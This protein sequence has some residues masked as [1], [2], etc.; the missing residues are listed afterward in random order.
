MGRGPA[1]PATVEQPARHR[2]P[3]LPRRRR[4]GPHRRHRRFRRRHPDLPAHS[5]R[6]PGGRVRPGEHDLGSHAG[7]VRLREPGPPAHRSEQHRDRR[8]RGAPPA[9]DGLGHGRL[10]R[11]HP[12]PRVPRRAP[13]LRALRGRRPRPHPPG[14]RRAQL[15]PGQPGGGLRLLPPLPPRRLGGAGPGGTPGSDR[16]G[17]LARLPAEP[18]LRPARASTTRPS[19]GGR[20]R[21]G[22]GQAPAAQRPSAAGGRPRVA[23]AARGPGSGPRAQ[24]VGAH[25]RRRRGRSSWIVAG[26]ACGGPGETSCTSASC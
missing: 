18:G 2:L 17:R 10:D 4:R 3:V 14:G 25:A 15:Q 9:D 13:G 6:R 16:S 12:V 1:R 19:S 26:T 7:R 23:A 20:G 22:R 5:R 21:G 8:L 11:S 24:P